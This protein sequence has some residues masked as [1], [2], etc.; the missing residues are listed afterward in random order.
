MEGANKMKA[1]EMNTSDVNRT[2]NLNLERRSAIASRAA[3]SIRRAIAIVLASAG[4]LFLMLAAGVMGSSRNAPAPIT[5]VDARSRPFVTAYGNVIQQVEYGLTPESVAATSDGGYFA[6]ALTDS[7]SGYGVN[8]VV[9]LSAS[10]RPQWQREIGCATGAPGDY[11]LGVSAQQTSDGGYIL[12]GGVLGCGSYPQRAMVEKLDA[13]GRVV[14]AFAYPA[15]TGDGV[16]WKIR[17]TADGGYIA[18][19]S[20]A[21]SGQ[22]AGALILK[23]DGAGT[24]QWQRK[25]GPIGSTTAYFNAVQQTSDGGYV[26]IGEYSVLG[27]SYPYPV[28]VLVASFDPSGN[29]RWQKGFNNV[30]DRGAASGYEHALAGIQTS[31][32]GYIVVGNWSNTPPSPFPQ[33]DSGGALLLK[34]NSSGNIEWQKAYNGGIYCYFNGFNTTCTLITA[35]VYSVHQTTDGGYVLAGLGNLELLDSVPQVPWMAKVDSAGNLLWQYFYYDVYSTGRPISQYFASSTPTN[36]GG[37]MA[38]G[39]TEK[40][41][42]TFLGELYAVKTDSSGFVGIC[43]QQHDATPLHSV[44]PAMTILSSS[45]PVL[46]T[47]TPGSNVSI[48]AQTTSVL[49]DDKCPAN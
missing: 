5:A 35:L 27:G 10:G 2:T 28:S 43:D 36:D 16:I 3:R 25:L 39:F 6:L 8:W 22:L 34:L 45:L 20:A 38:L 12:G 32:G 49:K 7:P 4:L 19:G 13:Q 44:D 14:W 11:A 48:R 40:N 37:F 46:T 31:D 33:E 9:K 29:V 17:Q 1:A 18:V 47:V 26:A 15:G 23:L 41:D 42:I 30:D 21:S 24:V